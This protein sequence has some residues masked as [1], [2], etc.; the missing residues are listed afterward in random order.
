MWVGVT[1]QAGVLLSQHTRVSD[2][3]SDTFNSNGVI[4]IHEQSDQ[5]SGNSDSGCGPS[6]LTA[7]SH[8]G[9]T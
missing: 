9:G 5:A 4:C 1:E 7:S 6:M 3:V 8:V 2:V